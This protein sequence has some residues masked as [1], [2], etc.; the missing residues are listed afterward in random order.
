MFETG[1]KSSF[2]DKYQSERVWGSCNKDFCILCLIVWYFFCYQ[3]VS[4]FFKKVKKK[5]FIQFD[6]VHCHLI[7]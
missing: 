4:D 6:N 3:T 2:L 1:I 7:T 5:Y